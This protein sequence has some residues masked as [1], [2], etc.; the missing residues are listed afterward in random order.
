MKLILSCKGEKIKCPNQEVMTG[1]TQVA[2]NN[3]NKNSGVAR[4]GAKSKPVK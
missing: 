2:D 1:L 4:S 3:K